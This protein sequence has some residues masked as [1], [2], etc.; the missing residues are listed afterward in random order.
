MT[1]QSLPRQNLHLRWQPRRLRPTDERA[2]DK[3]AK[4]LRDAVDKRKLPYEWMVKSREGHGFWNEGNR[5][6]LY[7]RM[8]AFLDKHI[9][10]GV[11]ARN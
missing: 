1:A 2:P 5:E 8:L 7:T 9:G 6:E 4:L 3:Q 11:P 10:A